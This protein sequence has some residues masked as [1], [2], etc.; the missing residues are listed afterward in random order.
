MGNDCAVNYAVEFQREERF[1][2]ILI[3]CTVIGGV[4]GCIVGGI[5]AAKGFCFLE[6]IKLGLLFAFGTCG[7]SAVCLLATNR[8]NLLTVVASSLCHFLN[9]CIFLSGLF[10]LTRMIMAIIRL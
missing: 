3:F 9:F 4:L 5:C 1:F 8:V 10:W 2:I 7:A 6:S